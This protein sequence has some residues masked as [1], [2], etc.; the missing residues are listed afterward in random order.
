MGK[1]E[2]EAKAQFE[3]DAGQTQTGAGD[4]LTRPL[5]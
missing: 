3:G 5:P 1:G 4:A 2:R